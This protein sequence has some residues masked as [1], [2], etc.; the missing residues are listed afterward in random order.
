MEAKTPANTRL[1]VSSIHRQGSHARKP[2]SRSS[3]NAVIV[4]NPTAG[5]H[6]PEEQNRRY[7]AGSGVSFAIQASNSAQ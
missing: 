7:V 6:R 4:R 1:I 5:R 3:A 2:I